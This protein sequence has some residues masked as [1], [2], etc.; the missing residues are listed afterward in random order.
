MLDVTELDVPRDRRVFESLSLANVVPL[1]RSAQLRGARRVR[2]HGLAAQA[3]TLELLSCLLRDIVI[4]QYAL[5]LFVASV[6]VAPL[7]RLPPQQHYVAFVQY[8]EALLSLKR[9]Q[10]SHTSRPASYSTSRACHLPS[11]EMPSF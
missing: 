2:V 9:I 8:P 11:Y 3:H 10:A 1:H 6:N 5:G 4:P 7:A